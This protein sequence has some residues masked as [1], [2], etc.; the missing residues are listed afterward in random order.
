MTDQTN[1]QEGSEDLELQVGIEVI[2]SYKRLSYTAWYAFAEFVDNSTQSYIDNKNELDKALKKE[3][4]PITVNIEYDRGGNFI[5]IWDNSIGM[6]KSEL[7]QALH[8][9]IPPKN[10]TQRSKYGLGMKTAACWF[11]NKWSV[12]TKKLGEDYA[13]KIDVDV[14]QVAS[15]LSSK[16]PTTI[17]EE[18]EE[19]HYTEIRIDNLNRQFHGNTLRKVKEFLNSMYRFDFDNI[20]LELTWQGK[21]LKWEGFKD[22]FYVTQDGK[23][24]K[25][26][27][28]FSIGDPAKKIHG[29]VGVLA[30]GSRK[31]AGFSLIQNNRVIQGWPNGYK[32]ESVFGEVGTNDL[33]NQ[34]VV[35]ELF[36]D[37]FA[38]SHTKDSIL[39]QDSE[40]EDLEKALE[41]RCQDAR[42][43]ARNIRVK[44][45][46]VDKVEK[47]KN[48][49]LDV[50][51]SE[52]KS[53]ELRDKL[54]NE[55][56]PET[57]VIQLSYKRLLESAKKTQSPS[58][59]VT[60]GNDIDAINVKV[61][62]RTAS[63][64][65]PYVLVEASS[66]ENLLLII[67]NTLHPY[68]TEL[69][70]TDNFLGFI[71]HCVYDGLSEWRAAKKL[72]RI[73]SDTVKYIKD[74]LLRL[75]FEITQN[76]FEAAMDENNE[77]SSA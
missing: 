62:F 75:P 16:L 9:G 43:L 59:E 38:V 74:L 25:V 67:I 65:E 28:N 66:E 53:D 69:K 58:L 44:D 13:V 57:K 10:N 34:R 3:G 39:W 4:V 17:S 30:K 54:F 15:N 32:P 55:I 46:K 49:A 37:G 56:I 33:I 64:F 72:G 51:E 42:A 48:A 19:E 73:N 20:G 35:G 70:T 76:Q 45:L 23:P 11:G 29:W 63:E 12:K 77:A 61:Y 52:L 71:R 22:R 21:Q 26:P 5:R 47:E 2:S 7:A 6:S 68:W 60:I 41:E 14:E 24:Y 50:F 18:K 36:V 27:L 8:I 31:D 40:E 1:N